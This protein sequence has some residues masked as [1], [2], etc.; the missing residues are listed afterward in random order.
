MK[1]LRIA[2]LA[3]FLPVWT[4]VVLAADPAIEKSIASPDRTAEDR[5]RDARD[6]PAEVLAFAG[7]KPGMTV[8]DIFSAI[9]EERPYRKSMDRERVIGV[10]RGDA[11]RGL[12]SERLVNLLVEHYEDINERRDAESRAASKTYQESLRTARES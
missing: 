1:S 4:A 11:E 5:E 6:K 12:L 2:L 3:L 9:T 10:L 8:A 7:V